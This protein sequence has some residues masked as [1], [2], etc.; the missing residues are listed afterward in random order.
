MKA[1]EQKAQKPE[2]QVK[3]AKKTKAEYM[4][5]LTHSSTHKKI[6]DAQER[7][8]KSYMKSE[9]RAKA[10]VSPKKQAR[11]SGDRGS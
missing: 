6:L 5:A 2:R 4:P 8:L 7:L 11:S 1:A 9:E 10:H 3:K